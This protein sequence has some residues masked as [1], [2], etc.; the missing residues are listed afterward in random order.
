[1]ADGHGY[2]KASAALSVALKNCGVTLS[3]C[4]DGVGDI[5]MVEALLAVATA[6]GAQRPLYHHAHP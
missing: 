4:I 2:H 1:M 3:E 5:A 6:C